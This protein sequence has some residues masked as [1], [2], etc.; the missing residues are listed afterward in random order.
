M[1][2]VEMTSMEGEQYVQEGG[3]IFCATTVQSSGKISTRV[4]APL[5]IPEI[6]VI[7]KKKKCRRPGER[8]VEAI[9]LTKYSEK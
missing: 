8:D 5:R 2:E 3:G 1:E 9:R 4:K 6:N 7:I